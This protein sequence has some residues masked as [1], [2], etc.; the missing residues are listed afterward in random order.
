MNVDD[1]GAEVIYHETPS[2]GA[3][4]SVGSITWTAAVLVDDACSRI[5]RNVLTRMLRV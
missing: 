4:F 2:G 1:G 5:T 3:V